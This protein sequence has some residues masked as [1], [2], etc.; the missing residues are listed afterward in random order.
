MR[1]RFGQLRHGSSAARSVPERS[2]T[3]P[4]AVARTSA[5]RLIGWRRFA[6]VRRLAAAVTP[7]HQT[8]L[9]RSSDAAAAVPRAAVA[10]RAGRRHAGNAGRRPAAA[11]VWPRR[12]PRRSAVPWRDGLRRGS[13][14]AAVPATGIDAKHRSRPGR[15]VLVPE[16]QR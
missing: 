13:R 3:R 4:R 15:G 16:I 12:G 9:R 10:R 11:G 7:V 8:P 5:R 6:S 2:T 1:R 14:C